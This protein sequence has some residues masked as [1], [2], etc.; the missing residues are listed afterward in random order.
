MQTV[1][2]LVYGPCSFCRRVWWGGVGGRL[3][4]SLLGRRRSSGWVGIYRG[5]I[6]CSGGSSSS[7]HAGVPEIQITLLNRPFITG[8]FVWGGRC[9]GGTTSVG[10]R[11]TAGLAGG[12]AV[13]RREECFNIIIYNNRKRR[14]YII[15]YLSWPC[16]RVGSSLPPP[17]GKD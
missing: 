7:R 10:R 2:G 15:I 17:D 6:S 9:D 13:P 14:V 11:V 3:F 8:S 16:A 5:C 12:D 1:E 4:K